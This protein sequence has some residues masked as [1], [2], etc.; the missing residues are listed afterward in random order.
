MVDNLILEN[1]K[2][3][4]YHDW[5]TNVRKDGSVTFNEAHS[6]ISYRDS[7]KCQLC[8]MTLDSVEPAHLDHIIPKSQ[9]G[10]NYLSNVHLS[11]PTCNMDKSI[12]RLNQEYDLRIGA[13]KRT[14]KYIPEDVAYIIYKSLNNHYGSKSQIPF[15]DIFFKKYVYK[16]Q[17]I[18]NKE[19]ENLYKM[20]I[21]KYGISYLD[22]AINAPVKREYNDLLSQINGKYSYIR[23]K[24]DW[25]QDFR[26][27][28][29]EVQLKYEVVYNCDLTKY[30]LK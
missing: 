24:N 15:S 16:P 28:A 10:H 20:E 30:K 21:E 9:Y 3:R 19:I 6:Y 2:T 22:I 1:F 25:S 7:L 26:V 29:S 4:E 27:F 8:G 11:C 17:I 13:L 5:I 12:D 14:I 23:S 18:N